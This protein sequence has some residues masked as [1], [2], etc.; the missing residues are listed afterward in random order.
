M[1]VEI[2]GGSVYDRT[3]TGAV[4]IH[5]NIWGED[6]VFLVK[7][8]KAPDLWVL[9]KGGLEEGLTPEEN[10]I[11]ETREEGGIDVQIV[12]SPLFDE[13]LSYEA[14]FGYRPKLQREIYFLAEFIKVSEVWDEE[15]L[16]EVGWFRMT[17]PELSKMTDIQREIVRRAYD[18]FK[19]KRQ[20]P[21]STSHR[22]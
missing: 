22:C 7:S 17:D 9:P 4:A 18:Q 11:K 19:T 3:A 16:R 14:Q 2:H 13:V 21:V 12:S 15:G 10:A 6:V 20:F 1:K 8:L 5:H